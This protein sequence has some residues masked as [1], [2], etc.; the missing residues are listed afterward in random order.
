M[1]SGMSWETWLLFT[2]T[3]AC[4]SMNCGRSAVKKTRAF[5][6]A[7][8]TRNPRPARRTSVPSPAACTPP[9]AAGLRNA[10]RPSQTR[11]A[12]PAHLIAENTS[13]DAIRTAPRLVADS[14]K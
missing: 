3:E 14:T 8:C 11:Y 12:A 13:C 1:L 6:F 2:I 5:G 10:R 9:S 4:G 7:T